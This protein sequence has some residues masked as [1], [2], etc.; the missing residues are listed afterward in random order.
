MS[1]FK[2]GQSIMAQS[3]HKFSLWENDLETEPSRKRFQFWVDCLQ[4][5]HA[6]NFLKVV[7]HRSSLTNEIKL[8]VRRTCLIKFSHTL[9]EFFAYII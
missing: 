9:Y 3:K 7:I 2:H 8:R 5:V 4:N 1:L 6:Q